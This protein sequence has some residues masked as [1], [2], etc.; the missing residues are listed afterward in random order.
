MI[1]RTKYT[2]KNLKM[3]TTINHT[4]KCKVNNPL[5]YT[6]QT[7]DTLRGAFYVMKRLMQTTV[8]GPSIG[9]ECY[10][11]LNW[12]NTM[13]ERH[14]LNQKLTQPANT[15]NT[16]TPVIM[17]IHAFAK[18]KKGW[19]NP[20]KIYKTHTI[21]CMKVRQKNNIKV[22]LIT[23]KHM[24]KETLSLLKIIKHTSKLLIVHLVATICHQRRHTIIVRW[25]TH[26]TIVLLNI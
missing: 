23:I 8:I 16:H 12:A 3:S 17:I 20:I 9:V 7:L 5:P 1:T 6:R 25:A 24:K 14:M 22:H 21:H 10:P 13:K 4:T 2:Q 11:P 26:L 19:R 18:L 15:L